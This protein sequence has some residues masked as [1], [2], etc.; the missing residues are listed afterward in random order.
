MFENEEWREVE[1]LPHYLIS[2]HGR[3]KRYDS[4]EIRKQTITDK[5]F[6]ALTLYGRDKKTRYFKQVNKLV[7]AAFL[8]PPFFEKET[9]VWHLD[10]DLNNCKAE[11]L[12]WET[13]A[14]VREWNEM[15]R[16]G[17]PS[18]VTPQ[19]KNNR[20]GIVYDN[21]FECAMAEGRLESDIVIRI[22][23]QARHE[24]DDNAR[25]RYIRGGHL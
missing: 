23:K 1:D 20:T 18:I 8:H 22:E 3:V 25:Y 15:N 13:L 24:E 21:A 19:V 6:P 16:T 10:G 12:K 17:T 2:N 7:A 11:N 4:D 9:S 5:G 14:R